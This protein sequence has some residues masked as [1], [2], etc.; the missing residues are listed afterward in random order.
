MLMNEKGPD[1]A[2][3]VPISKE[4]KENMMLRLR[5][6]LQR[7]MIHFASNMATFPV[8]GK[9]EYEAAVK[10]RKE[11]LIQHMLAF[12]FDP[13]KKSWTGK[14]GADHLDDDVLALT[15][16]LYNAQI[17]YEDPRYLRYHS[18]SIG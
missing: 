15:H 18:Q 12:E 10:L 2:P 16:V 7:D 9:K 5:R 3:G 6:L 17:F 11:T 1:K 14:K 13:I 4:I 8:D